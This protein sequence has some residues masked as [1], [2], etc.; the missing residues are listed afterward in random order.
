MPPTAELFQLRSLSHLSA[1]TLGSTTWCTVDELR[2]A[3]S[4]RSPSVTFEQIS[5][6]SCRTVS[7]IA[8]STLGC[9]RRSS[10]RSS[11][12]VDAPE[13]VSETGNRSTSRDLATPCCLLESDD[14]I[15]WPEAAVAAALMT[16]FSKIRRVVSV[17]LGL[18]TVTFECDIS[19]QG[20]DTKES[21]ER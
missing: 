2:L 8:V 16:F 5:L 17:T 7:I 20:V 19:E 3:S 12:A 6:A 11:S 9:C 14:V 15:V 21:N 10:F 13:W 1:V 4:L 18:S